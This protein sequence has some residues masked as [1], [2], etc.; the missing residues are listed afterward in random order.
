MSL[1]LLNEGRLADNG[2]LS[3]EFEAGLVTILTFLARFLGTSVSVM[4]ASSW[5]DGWLVR[6]RAELTPPAINAS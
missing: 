6:W 5:S 4:T 1:D 2:S 3:V